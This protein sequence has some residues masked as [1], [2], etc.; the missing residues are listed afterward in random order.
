M[1]GDWGGLPFFPYRTAIESAVAKQMGGFA[2]EHNVEFLLALG[3][4]FYYDGVKDVDDPR[5]QVHKGWREKK[6]H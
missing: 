6:H 2:S 1:L 4:N 3:D 5:F